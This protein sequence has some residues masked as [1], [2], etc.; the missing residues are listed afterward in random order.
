MEAAE[1][2]SAL[3]LINQIQSIGTRSEQQ[4]HQFGTVIQSCL[5]ECSVSLKICYQT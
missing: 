5:H 3:V 1:Q 2:R 4:L